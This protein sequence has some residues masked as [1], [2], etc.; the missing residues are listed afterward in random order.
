MEAGRHVKYNRNGNRGLTVV[1][2]LLLA[3]AVIVVVVLGY[4]QVR[5]MTET[6]VSVWVSASPLTAGQVVAAGNVRATQMPPPSGAIVNRADIE[7]RTL[8][9]DKGAGQPFYSTDLVARP[10]KPPL[11]TTIPEGRLLATLRFGSMDL[12][13]QELVAGDRLDIL[14]AA[15]DG[16]HVVAHDAYMLGV[17]TQRTPNGTGDSGRILGVDISIPGANVD[18]PAGSALVLGLYPEEVFSLAAAEATG[19]QLKLVLH[20]DRE[21][22]AGEVMDLRPD[23]EPPPRVPPEPP[24]VE[25]L[26]GSKSETVR[27]R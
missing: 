6:R 1:R 7:G 2:A 13:T 27:V 4:R 20:S 3:A 11:S 19:K 12:P 25:V 26:L 10:P 21:V 15:T 14:L 17:L 24:T 18:T 5:R 8:L 16:V 23:P 22:K 9:K